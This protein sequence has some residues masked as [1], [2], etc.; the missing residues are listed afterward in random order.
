MFK[1]YSRI[2]TLYLRRVDVFVQIRI[3][4]LVPGHKMCFKYLFSILIIHATTNTEQLPGT[5]TSFPPP[6]PR[7]T[8]LNTN[9]IVEQK[10]EDNNLLIEW[11]FCQI[12]VGRN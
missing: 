1:A 7:K 11:W 4:M 12:V 8:N 9:R 3:L 5:E 6:T 10:R 2:I